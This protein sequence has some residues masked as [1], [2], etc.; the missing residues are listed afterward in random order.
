VLNE[1]Q[2]TVAEL[3]HLA[4]KVSAQHLPIGHSFIPFD[5]LLQVYLHEVNASSRQLNIKALFAALPYSEMGMR[6]HLRRL[7]ESDWLVVGKC[8][9]DPRVRLV[10]AT[11][12][13]R[14]RFN[15]VTER[16]GL[17]LRHQ[18]REKYKATLFDA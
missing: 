7:I 18:P 2:K 12:K 8:S 3:L 15:R 1:Q 13:T 6:Y 5:L 16:L 4:R 17:F 11:D 10:S 9:N 14:A